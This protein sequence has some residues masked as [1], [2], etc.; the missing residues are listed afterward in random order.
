MIL[1]IQRLLMILY[2]H[3]VVQITLTMKE[4]EDMHEGMRYFGFEQHMFMI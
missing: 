1:P 3:K 4:K 2:M